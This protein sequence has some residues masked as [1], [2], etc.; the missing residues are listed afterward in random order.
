MSKGIDC[1]SM[2]AIATEVLENNF[3]DVEILNTFGDD[4]AM[5]VYF[6][7]EDNEVIRCYEFEAD[8]AVVDRWD[9]Y[10]EEHYT[11]SG[12]WTV[13]MNG[14]AVWDEFDCTF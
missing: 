2:R 10:E 5:M 7:C 12:D 14:I 3:D 9:P 8:Y 11:T 6:S 1:P 13:S 4:T